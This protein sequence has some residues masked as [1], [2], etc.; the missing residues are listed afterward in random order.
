MLGHFQGRSAWSRT[1]WHS[2]SHL[3][4]GCYRLLLSFSYKASFGG[5]N[6]AQGI[7]FLKGHFDRFTSK[8]IV[9]TP[10]LHLVAL[11]LPF[12]VNGT[13]A[14]FFISYCKG[15]DPNS[16]PLSKLAYRVASITL[17]VSGPHTFNALSSLP[18]SLFHS[19]FF[20]NIPH[21]LIPF[22]KT[23]SWNETNDHAMS[24]IMQECSI[25]VADTPR[26]HTH[27]HTHTRWRTF[28]K[29]PAVLWKALQPPPVE[30]YPILLNHLFHPWRSWNGEETLHTAPLG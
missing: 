9:L 2:D 5:W 30:S 25:I 16:A 1:Q 3:A 4:S 24:V 14:L 21:L 11:D 7:W 27:T 29:N 17:D 12:R 19:F 26:I 28:P 23:H 22:M 10:K 8:K 13:C 6:P 20:S 18:L 15:Q